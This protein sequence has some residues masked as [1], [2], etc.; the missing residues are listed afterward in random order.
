MS[1]RISAIQAFRTW[2][3]SWVNQE[4]IRKDGLSQIGMNQMGTNQV[5]MKQVGCPGSR[6]ICETREYRTT[7]A[8]FDGIIRCFSRNHDVMYMALAETRAAD[9]NEACLLQEFRNGRASAIAHPRL[10]SAHHL[11]NNHGD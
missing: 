4:A 2:C 10:Q 3:R 11:V 7:R 5:G 1:H 9:A 8:L 6:C